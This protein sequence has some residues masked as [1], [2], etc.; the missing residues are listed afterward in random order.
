MDR[1]SFPLGSRG[2]R[3]ASSSILV[4]LLAP[5]LI[6]TPEARDDAHVHDDTMPMTPEAMKAWIDDYYSRNPVVLPEQAAGVA[7]ATFDVQNFSFELNGG[8]PGQIDTAFIMENEAVAWVHV[9]G[10]HTVTNGEGALDPQAGTVFD[11][12]F[13]GSGFFTH[14]YSDPGTFP[15]FCRPHE[16]SEMKGVVVV[17]AVADVAKLP[18]DATGIGF[19][20][21]PFPVPT[22]GG[23][24]FRFALARAGKVEARIFDAGG[25]LV[26]IPVDRVLEP[27]AYGGAWDGRSRAGEFV[28]PGVYYL[29]LSVPG[30]RETRRLVVSR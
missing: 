20:A 8:T 25:R 15:F 2:L 18:G 14:T 9:S 29:R 1:K 30:A 22:R 27:G 26:A 16:L 3:L 19:T 4:A 6:T 13:D 24:T 28:T 10:F 12:P 17:Q 5:A 11:V 7:A 21:A 23:V